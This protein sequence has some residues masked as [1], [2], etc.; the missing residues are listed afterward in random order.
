[1][2]GA[3]RLAFIAA[4][5]LGAIYL[6]RGTVATNFE[7]AVDRHEPM[8]YAQTSET[9]RD[10]LFQTLRQTQQSK[11]LIWMHNSLQ[12]PTVWY[13]RDGA[14]W[15]GDSPVTFTADPGDA[16]LRMAIAT[17]DVWK[18]SKRFRGWTGHET[19]FYIWPRASWPALRPAVWARFWWTREAT[20]ENGVL[21]PPGEWPGPAI[22]IIGAPP[23]GNQPCP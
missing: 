23:C 8:F 9:F 2:S 4:C 11:D 17:P 13:T 18:S 5:A 22:A 3:R 19:N 6:L 12:W 10:A 20:V 7:R 21:A 1:L 14:P 15:R 16:P